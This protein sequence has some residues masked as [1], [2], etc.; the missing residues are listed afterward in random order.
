VPPTAV[1]AGATGLVGSHC[2][3]LLASSREYSRVIALVRRNS[4]LAGVNVEERVIDFDRLS[5]VE[6][7]RGADVFCALGTTIRT[8]GSREAFRR[9]DLDYPVTLA[10]RAAA[11]G[12]RQFLVVSSISADAQ[13]PNFY[14]RTKGEMERQLSEL[15]FEA[16]HIFRPSF[17]IGHRQEPRRG[18]KTGIAVARV[19]GFTLVGPL[20]KYRAIPAEEVASAMVRAALRNTRGIHIHHFE[21][22]HE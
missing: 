12:A 5:T 15:P 9:V 2:L 18:E 1:I 16:L 6:I 20:R 21:E 7:S 22:M 19:I 10:D 3:R 17:L 8:A 14:L 4:G 11:L 13:S